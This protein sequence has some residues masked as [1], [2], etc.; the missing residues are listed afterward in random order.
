MRILANENFP[1]PVIRALRDRGHDVVSVKETISGAD[2]RRVLDLAGK[3]ARLVVTLDKD[4]GE[5]AFRFG[6]PAQSGVVFSGCPGR[7]R[8]WTTRGHWPCWK[9]ERTGQETSRW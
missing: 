7:A 8:R 2:Y 3:Q 9:A 4:F 6:L 5:L 1:G